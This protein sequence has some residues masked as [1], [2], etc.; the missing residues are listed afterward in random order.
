MNKQQEFSSTKQD[1]LCIL[2]LNGNYSR[3]VYLPKRDF[4]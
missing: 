3:D 1:E 4:S 2:L